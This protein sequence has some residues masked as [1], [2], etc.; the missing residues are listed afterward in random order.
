M[1]SITMLVSIFMLFILVYVG[2]E[3]W[4]FPPQWALPM[5][6]SLS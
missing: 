1:L 6:Y 2:G 4:G 5:L 3:P